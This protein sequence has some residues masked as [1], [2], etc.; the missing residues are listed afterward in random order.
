[1]LTITIAIITIMITIIDPWWNLSWNHKSRETR[2]VKATERQSGYS[3]FIMP[4][5]VR[6]S[7]L[8]ET[9]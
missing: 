8:A 4:I 3:K 1:M 6:V 2:L 5:R 7:P 9:R